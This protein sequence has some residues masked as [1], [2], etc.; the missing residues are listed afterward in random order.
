MI[1]VYL[2]SDCVLVKYFSDLAG[3]QLQP[4]NIEVTVEH[5]I[6]LST[7]NALS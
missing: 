4:I 3:N 7:P 5:M 2:F 1:E 6:I